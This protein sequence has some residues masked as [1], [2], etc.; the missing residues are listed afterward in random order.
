MKEITT[1]NPS[2]FRCCPGRGEYEDK[3]VLDPVDVRHVGCA[4]DVTF[5]SRQPRAFHGRYH[6]VGTD[7]NR[8]E[9]LR[10]RLQPKKLEREPLRT[11]SHVLQAQP[12]RPGRS[13]YSDPLPGPGLEVPSRISSGS[14]CGHS[15]RSL[16]T[17][18]LV[19]LREERERQ[20]RIRSREAKGGGTEC[21]K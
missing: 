14:V 4:C 6:R 16:E 8:G 20:A 13:E 17:A 3:S 18:V 15:D 5:L 21:P 1:G 12:G 10:D 7:R 19:V 9:H 2:C 11:R